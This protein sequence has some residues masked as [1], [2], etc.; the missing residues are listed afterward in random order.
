MSK[1]LVSKLAMVVRNPALAGNLLLDELQ[2]AVEAGAADGVSYDISEPGSPFVL[3]ME[4]NVMTV[5]AGLG[6]IEAIHRKQYPSMALTDQELY[7]HMADVDYANRFAIPSWTKFDFFIGREELLAKAISV[8]DGGVRKLVIPRGTYFE[9]AE[10]RFTMQYPIELRVL[11]NGAIQISYDDTNPSP[12]QTLSSNIVEWDPLKYGTDKLIRLRI[13]VGQFA[14][15]TFNAVLNTA[16]G[17]ETDYSFEDQFYYARV[18][19]NHSDDI[20]STTWEEIRTTHTDQV[21]DAMQLTAVLSVTEG[22]LKVKIPLVYFNNGLDGEVRVDVYTT[23]GPLSMDLGSYKPEEFSFRLVDLDDDVTYVSPLNTFSKIRAMSILKVSGGTNGV[24]I[25]TLRTQVMTN[26]VGA[27]QIPISPPQ[28]ENRLTR[29][30]GF[31]VVTSVDNVTDLQFLASK[32]MPA[33]TNKSVSGGIGTAMATLQHT[34]SDLVRSGGV[35]NNGARITMSPDLLYQYSSGQVS[36]MSDTATQALKAL[37]PDAIV[38]EV[39]TNRYMFSP[40]HHVLDTTGS[41]FD[42]RPYYLDQPSVES[43]SSAGVNPTVLMQASI[44]GYELVRR[45]YGYEL[46]ISLTSDDSFKALDDSVVVAQ[47]GY[48]PFGE[49]SYASV[50]GTLLTKLDDERVYR[51]EIHTHFDIDR[52]DALHTTNLSMFDNTQRDFATLLESD[53]DVSFIITNQDNSRY[54]PGPLDLLI[55]RHLLLTQDGVQVIGRERLRCVLGYSMGSLWHPNRTVPTEQSYET[56]EFDVPYVYEETVFVRDP[57]TGFPNITMSN[58]GQIE[59]EVLYERGTNAFN[60]DGT[61]RMRY[62]AGQLK[63]DGNDQPILKSARQLLREFTMLL[64]DGNYYFVEDQESLDYRK[65]APMVVVNWLRDLGELNKNLLAG[66]KVYLYPTS[67]LGDTTALVRNGIEAVL[68]IDQRLWIKYTLTD[69]AY[70][71]EVLREALS[72]SSKTILV[73]LLTRGVVAHSEAVGRLRENAGEDVVSFEF[74]GFGGSAN[75]SSVTLTDNSVRLALGKRLVVKPNQLLGV[76][77]D[78]DIQFLPESLVTK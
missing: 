5:A 3:L 22:R 23:K 73:S 39:T 68:P 65:E 2:L 76:E 9:I 59:Y 20:D 52:N 30:L 56:W 62:T 47:L 58:E 43:K 49:T 46:T 17:F 48:K 13:P 67:T 51:F 44:A 64:F 70:R 1:A 15:K 45:E 42:C 29:G 27:N 78:I 25:A 55:T 60:D 19:I 24:D 8:G 71:N 72:A 4:G 54:I 38:R 77:D 50:N 74:G 32:P 26:S 61:V 40:F 35:Y 53:F 7:L 66:G 18:Y 16:V 6:E 14:V 21:Y 75:Y 63:R 11:A 28:L 10:T 34:I 12:I 57:I 33:P 37:A 36:I 41:E 69:K 31:S